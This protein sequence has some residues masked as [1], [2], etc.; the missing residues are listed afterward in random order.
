M[1]LKVKQLLF[2]LLAM[3][4]SVILSFFII[5]LY[6]KYIDFIFYCACFTVFEVPKY[7][8]QALDYV[9]D[10]GVPEKE[11]I[12]QEKIRDEIIAHN[13]KK[14]EFEEWQEKRR[15]RKERLDDARGIYYDD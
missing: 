6:V 10:T 13:K 1:Y 9:L 14:K 15:I 7:L 12:R 8:L 5:F 2:D 3:M 11:R 4:L